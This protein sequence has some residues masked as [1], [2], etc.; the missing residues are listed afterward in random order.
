MA[1]VGIGAIGAADSYIVRFRDPF[2]HVRSA[3]RKLDGM[4]VLGNFFVSRAKPDMES[5]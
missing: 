5:V 1:W 3:D 2:G 4:I